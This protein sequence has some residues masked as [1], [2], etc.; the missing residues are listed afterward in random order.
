MAFAAKVRFNGADEEPKKQDWP[1]SRKD[2][3]KGNHMERNQQHTTPDDDTPITK[4]GDWLAEK[5]VD[6]GDTLANGAVSAIDALFGKSD[7]DD[8]D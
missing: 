5:T 2:K 3:R 6:V 8:E 7:S 4:T 1:S